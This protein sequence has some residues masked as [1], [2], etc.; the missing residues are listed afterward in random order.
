MKNKFIILGLAFLLAT[1]GVKVFAENNQSSYSPFWLSGGSNIIPKNTNWSLGMGTTSPYAKLSI[2]GSGVF[3]NNVLSSYFTA[4]ST[5]ASSTFPMIQGSTASGGNLWLGSTDH[6]T[7][8]KI[9]FGTSAYDEVNN[10]LGIGTASPSNLLHVMGTGVIG[11]FDGNQQNV[12]VRIKSSASNKES[13]LYFS[14]NADRFGLGVDA[15]TNDFSIK[16][17]NGGV[18]ATFTIGYNDGTITQNTY[19][20]NATGNEIAYQLNYTTNKLTSGKDTGLLINQTDTASPGTSVLL[21]VQRNGTSVFAVKPTTIELGNA[22]DAWTFT[23][24][25]PRTLSTGAGMF[26]RGIGGA[27]THITFEQGQNN[28]AANPIFA[29]QPGD[30]TTLTGSSAAQVYLAIKPTYNQTGTAGGTDLLINRTQTAVGSGLQLLQDWQVG[31]V[32]KA[33]LSNTG[34]LSIDGLLYINDVNS[35]NYIEIGQNGG[36]SIGGYGATRNIIIRQSEDITSGDF[37]AIAGNANIELTAASGNQAFLKVAANINQS[38]TAAA[39]DLLINRTQTAVGSGAQLL[40]DAQVGGVSK[41]SVSNTGTTTIAVGGLANSATCW[42]ADGK[43]IGYC[44]SAV[45]ADGTCTCN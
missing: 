24:G 19:L 3:D 30:S 41:F 20:D 37:M 16:S 44:S 10:R 33:Q 2:S 1:S 6:A 42:K 40:I 21:D 39:T 26:L 17:L 35:A 28:T 11:I 8:G 38:G 31:G 36:L 9:L 14:N 43:T 18:P 45:A 22:G 23:T 5:T 27:N 7:K 34:T 29:F 4:T 25:A 15:N 13:Q 12:Y 32:S